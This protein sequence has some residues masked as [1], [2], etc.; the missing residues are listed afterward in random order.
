MED[1]RQDNQQKTM[2]QY[3]QDKIIIYIYKTKDKTINKTID[4]TKRQDKKEQE[5]TGINSCELSRFRRVNSDVLRYD[6]R[7]RE[8]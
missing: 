1:N 8:G 5:E 3:R 7:D 6:N 2:D 4:K